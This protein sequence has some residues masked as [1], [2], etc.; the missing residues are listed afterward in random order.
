ME[1]STTTNQKNILFIMCDQLR[2]DYLSCYGHPTLD[3]PNIDRLASMGVRFE[4]AYVQ[5]PQCGPSRACIYTGRYMT[6][7][8]SNWNRIPL[9]PHEKTIGD[10]LKPL[11]YRTAVVGKTHMRPDLDTYSRLGLDAQDANMELAVHAGFEPYERDDGLNPSQ[12]VSKDLR[13]N[14]HL[15][16]IGYETENPWQENANNV[17]DEAGNVKNGW[18]MENNHLAANVRE[19]DSETAYM[20]NRAMQFMDETSQEG[21]PWCLHLSYIKPHWPY[22]APAPYHAMYSKDDMIPVQRSE[23][24]KESA[25]PVFEHFMAEAGSQTM[26]RNDVR[27]K[28][29]PAYMGL[30]KQIDDHIGRL[31]DYLEETGLLANTMIVFTSDHGDYLGDH[32]LIEKL[33]FHDPSVRVPLIIYDPSEE[34]KGAR[35]STCPHLIES[36]DLLPTFLDFA[37]GDL[38]AQEHRLEG[39]S[40]LPHLRGEDIENWR[41]CAVAEI[42]FHTP[43]LAKQYNLPDTECRAFMIFDGR[44]KYILFDHFRAQLFD[45]ENDPTEVTDL[46]ESA[47]HSEIRSKLHEKLFTWLRRRKTRT[48]VDN[49]WYYSKKG[50]EFERKIGMLIGYYDESDLENRS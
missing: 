25:H 2:Y 7:H 35:A 34:A 39:K 6:S 36:I 31:L 8:G 3:T 33:L 40:L 23:A 18:L 15:Q 50:A 32:Y 9:P 42:D 47:Q 44:Y 17:V 45:L 28:A 27:E 37:G 4:H 16:S 38:K 5:A 1:D 41:D 21:R 46:G 20:T 29:I 10:Y 43:K 14:K 24:E 22:V 49:E 30:I 12:I 13:Y 48:T 26:A 11:G 19:E